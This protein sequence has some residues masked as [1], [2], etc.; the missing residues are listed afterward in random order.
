MLFGGGLNNF[1]RKM[2]EIPVLDMMDGGFVSGSALK[3]SS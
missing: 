1:G 3:I 2:A